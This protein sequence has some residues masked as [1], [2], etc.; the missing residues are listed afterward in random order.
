M[1]HDIQVSNKS[2]A[3]FIIFT[4]KSRFLKKIY[5]HRKLILKLKNLREN[6]IFRNVHTHPLN[7]HFRHTF[8]MTKFFVN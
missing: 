1:Q 8:F 7:N 6:I 2:A 4:L 3:Y 5:L